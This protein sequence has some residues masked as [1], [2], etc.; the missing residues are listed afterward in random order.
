MELPED[1]LF[2]E[3]LQLAK[4]A[5]SNDIQKFLPE[6]STISFLEIFRKPSPASEEKPKEAE[7]PKDTAKAP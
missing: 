2:I 7:P 6:I 5:I 3:G 4:R 1:A